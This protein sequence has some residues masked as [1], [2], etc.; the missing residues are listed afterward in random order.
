MIQT[1]IRVSDD[2]LIEA[3]AQLVEQA[4]DF[5]RTITA[6][7]ANR[8][9]PEALAELR[10]V[11]GPPRYPIRWTSERQRRA[12]FASDGFGGGIPTQRTGRLVQGWRMKVI[13]SAAAIT[14]IAFENPVPYRE[15]VTGAR[16]QPF[17]SVT[18]W[19]SDEVVLEYYGEVF[20]D[21]IETD[22]IKAFE[23]VE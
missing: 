6:R 21:A 22:L 23:A 1:T 13:Y 15:Y 5:V 10:R 7:T 8:L 4:P 16:R 20:A 12:F 17:H 2:G 11:P 14:E 9:A 18:G 19:Q 3:Y